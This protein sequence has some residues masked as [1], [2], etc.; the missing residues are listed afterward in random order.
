MRSLDA[1]DPASFAEK[2]R[3]RIGGY[4]TLLVTTAGG[5]VLE[6][7]VG[8][9]GAEEVAR[10]LRA[11]GG[12]EDSAAAGDCATALPSVRVA[13]AREQHEDAWTALQRGCPEPAS[14]APLPGALVLAFE[15]ASQVEQQEQALTY[16][17]A[18]AAREEDLGT[19]ARLAHEAALLLDAERPDDAQALRERA[20]VR[21]TEALERDDPGPDVLISLA[22]ALYYRGQWSPD[23]T[24]DHGRGADLLGR[25]ITLRA[26]APPGRLPETVLA[27]NEGLREHE[28]LVHD[29]IYLLRS[30]G[31]HDDVGRMYGAMLTLFPEAFTWHYAQ[32][33]WLIERGALDKAEPAARRAL[34]HSYGDMSLRAAKRLAEILVARGEPDDALATIDQALTAPLPTEQ[35]VRTWRYRKALTAL[36][37]TISPPGPR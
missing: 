1:D 35:H 34:E 14:L 27:L 8:F 24:E 7:I 9:P 30:A 37:D 18:G 29:Y 10:R 26:K 6:R 13:V 19:A 17:L 22:D 25:A 32:A 4:P 28:G 2:D 33:G 5:E 11:V 23:P 20:S 21:I 36:R 12:D 31:R 3:Y 16:A 15:L